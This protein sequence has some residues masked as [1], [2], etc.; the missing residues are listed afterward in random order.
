M[1]LLPRRRE[2]TEQEFRDRLA[3]SLN[4]TGPADCGLRS[5]NWELATGN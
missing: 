3:V 2:R 5:G 1:L 4:F